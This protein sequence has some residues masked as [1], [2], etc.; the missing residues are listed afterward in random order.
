MSTNRPG[1]LQPQLR[2]DNR[3]S[4]EGASLLGPLGFILAKPWLMSPTAIPKS[5]LC[6]S[7]SDG[8]EQ[9]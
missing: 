8:K 5:H 1:T 3:N 9:T 6:A 4:H 7:A 2:G